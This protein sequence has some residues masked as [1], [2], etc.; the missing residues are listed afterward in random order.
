MIGIT[1]HVDMKRRMIMKLI[2]TRTDIVLLYAEF[3]EM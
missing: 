2:Y 3:L 1:A